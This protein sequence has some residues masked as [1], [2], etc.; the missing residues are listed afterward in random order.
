MLQINSP[1]L[2]VL[3]TFHCSD[4]TLTR[5]TYHGVTLAAS[6]RMQSSVGWKC[7][8]AGH[9]VTS[10]GGGGGRKGEREKSE[11]KACWYSALS[12]LCL[13]GTPVSGIAPPTFRVDILTSI[14]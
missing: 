1:F 2:L 12:P 7:K 5:V 6:L 4:R 3:V 13:L 9:M 8:V 14:N 10:G 11:R